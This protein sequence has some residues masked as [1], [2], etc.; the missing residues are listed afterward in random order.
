M[1]KSIPDMILPWNLQGWSGWSK[2][3]ANILKNYDLSE[4]VEL[5]A[6]SWKFDI[7]LITA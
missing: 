7:L 6:I 4:Y 2:K 3:D 5:G 1:E